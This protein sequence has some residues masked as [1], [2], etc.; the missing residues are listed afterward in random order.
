MVSHDGAA[1]AGVATIAVGTD[2]SDTAARAVEFAVEMASRYGSQLV[3]GTCYQPVDEGRLR[4]EQRD[5]PGEVKWSISPTEDAEAAL[6]HA[7][8][9]AA[10]RGLDVMSEARMGKPAKVLCDIAA[11]YRADVLVVGSKG[12]HRKV[13]GSVPNTV[14]HEAPCS[15]VVVKTD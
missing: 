14:S 15:V 13:L 11:D 4:A 10:E 3:V 12:M 8:D 1:A 9:R 5:A 6:R 7:E 2:G